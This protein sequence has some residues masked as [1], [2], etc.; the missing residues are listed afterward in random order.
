MTR[1]AHLK[2]SKDLVGRGHSKPRGA[3]AVCKPTA[4]NSNIKILL[5]PDKQNNPNDGPVMFQAL[6][7]FVTFKK[8]QIIPK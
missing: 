8:Q 1:E 7:G 6:F 3:N 4:N 2:L 5:T